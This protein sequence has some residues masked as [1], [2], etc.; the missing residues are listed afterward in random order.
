MKEVRAGPRAD[1]FHSC[2]ELGDVR[3]EDDL[4]AVTARR[5]DLRLWRTP[6]PHDGDAHVRARRRESDRLGGVPRAHGH[7][8]ARPLLLGEARHREGGSAGLERSGALEVLGL[9]VRVRADPLSKRA[10]REQRCAV[11][12]RRDDGSRT[13]HV[14]E[15]DAH[16]AVAVKRQVGYV[17]GETPQFGGWRGSMIVAYV[18]GLRGGV[19]DAVVASLAKRLDLDLGRRY[20][21][22]S[23]GNKQKLLLVLAFMH[24]PTLL[25]LDEP[26]GGL[27][28]LHQQVF[29]ELIREARA[30][31][32]TV[33]LSSHV[34]S[35]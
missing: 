22:Y 8:P 20:R 12:H 33:F 14:G 9:Q 25:I 32:T 1:L 31:G 21:E 34:L 5:V 18:A 10:A 24:R 11:H 15:R 17:P 23:H 3:R 2:G 7:D 29:Y 35:E 6:R 4:R 28:P 16:A 30:G 27:D 13:F 26:T 19:S